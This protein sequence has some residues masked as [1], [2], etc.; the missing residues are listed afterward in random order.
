MED[1]PQLQQAVSGGALVDD[2]LSDPTD[3]LFVEQVSGTRACCVQPETVP[4]IQ[5]TFQPEGQ[6]KISEEEVKEVSESARQDKYDELIALIESQQFNDVVEVEL[7]SEPTDE[8]QHSE[9]QLDQVEGRHNMEESCSPQQNRQSLQLVLDTGQ[10]STDVQTTTTPVLEVSP[11]L[12]LEVK[13]KRHIIEEIVL[14]D[15]EKYYESASSNSSLKKLKKNSTVKGSLPESDVTVQAAVE[16]VSPADVEVV[17][18]VES[19]TKLES[20]PPRPPCSTVNSSPSDSPQT[21]TYIVHHDVPVRTDRAGKSP[22]RKS[23]SGSETGKPESSATAV[24]ERQGDTVN[25]HEAVNVT[26]L[27]CKTETA[28]VV[29]TVPL[30]TAS[31]NTGDVKG[32]LQTVMYEVKYQV[33][34]NKKK[35]NVKPSTGS[36]VVTESTVNPSTSAHGISESKEQHPESLY[37]AIINY[38]ARNVEK[39][40]DQPSTVTYIT[41]YDY[42]SLNVKRPITAPQDSKQV[43][44]LEKPCCQV[45]RQVEMVAETCNVGVQPQPTR[46]SVHYEQQTDIDTLLPSI[47]TS[48]H[49]VEPTVEHVV[50]PVV[51]VTVPLAA[52]TSPAQPQAVDSN[53]ET[54]TYVIDS[55]V[56]FSEPDIDNPVTVTSE[57]QCKAS[58]VTDFKPSNDVITR[59]Y[60][61]HYD[62]PTSAK[63]KPSGKVTEKQPTEPEVLKTKSQQ[64][65]GD[66]KDVVVKQACLSTQ[67][68][69]ITYIVHYDLPTKHR[70]LAKVKKPSVDVSDTGRQQLVVTESVDV[71]EP[72][73]ELIST[74][75]TKVHKVEVSVE[76]V[77]VKQVGACSDGATGSL[78]LTGTEET[79]EKSVEAEQH[80]QTITYIIN[81]EQPWNVKPHVLKS[82]TRS[83]RAVKESNIITD[84]SE[85]CPSAK[86]L[87]EQPK[88]LAKTDVNDVPLTATCVIR[89][90]AKEGFKETVDTEEEQKLQVQRTDEVVS[91]VEAITESCHQQ[92]GPAVQPETVTYIVNYEPI[93]KLSDT[94]THHSQLKEQHVLG[95]KTKQVSW[96]IGKKRQVGTEKHGEIS[97]VS[98]E[99][100]TYVI[101][102]QI[103]KKNKSPKNIFAVKFKDQSSDRKVKDTKKPDEKEQKVVLDETSEMQTV[104]A[105]S[106]VADVPDTVTYEQ[107]TTPEIVVV[108]APAE[109]LDPRTGEITY[110]VE[111]RL[112]TD[113]RG[114]I[115]TDDVKQNDSDDLEVKPRPSVELTVKAQPSESENRDYEV[116][117][118]CVPSI[119]LEP[120]GADMTHTIQTFELAVEEPEI[121]PAKATVAASGVAPPVDLREETVT[122]IVHYA[123]LDQLFVRKNKTRVS[124]TTK[125]VKKQNKKKAVTEPEK[126]ETEEAGVAVVKSAEETV[127]FIVTYPLPER[128]KGKKSSSSK[129]TAAAGPGT[130]SGSGETEVKVEAEI[131]EV[132]VETSKEREMMVPGQFKVEGK[133]EVVSTAPSI[134][135]YRADIVPSNL[136]SPADSETVIYVVHH[137]E[138][139]VRQQQQQPRIDQDQQSPTGKTKFALFGSRHSTNKDK[140]LVTGELQGTTDITEAGLGTAVTEPVLR[141]TVTGTVGTHPVPGTTVTSSGQLETDVDQLMVTPSPET[142]TYIVQYDVEPSISASKAA[143]AIEGSAKVRPKEERVMMTPLDD[144]PS[145]TTQ[146]TAPANDVAVTS[147]VRHFVVIAIDFGTT[148]SGYAFSFSASLSSMVGEDQM[149]E[150]QPDNVHVMRRWEGGDPGVVNH[151]APTTLLL[152][153]TGEFHSFGFTARDFYHDLSARQAKKWLYFDKFKMVLHNNDELNSKTE[154]AASNG[155]RV[156]ATMVF[157]HALRFFRKHAIQEISDQCGTKILTDDIRWV[158]TVPSIWQEP[159]KQ[160]MRLAAYQAGIGSI[161]K[162]EQL[163][164][165]LEPEAASIYVRKLHLHQLV[166]EGQEALCRPKSPRSPLI[167]TPEPRLADVSFQTESLGQTLTNVYWSVQRQESPVYNISTVADQVD[168]PGTRYMVVDCGGGTVDITVHELSSDNCSL[169]ELYKATGGPFGSMAVDAEFE[170]LLVNIF[171]ADF[172][173][174]FKTKRPAGW[175]D[176]MMAFESRKRAANPLS[177]KPLNVSLPFSFIDYHKKYRNGPVETAVRQYNNSDVIWSSQGMLRLLPGAM[178]RLFQPTLDNIK[179]AIGNVL[180]QPSVRGVKF[181]FLVGGFAE[182]PMLQTDIRNEFQ[183]LLKIIIP[184]EVSLAVL[185]GAVCFGVNPNVVTTRRSL[186]TYGVSVVRPFVRGR[187][188]D[189]KLIKLNDGSEWCGDVFDVLVLANQPV[190]L[191][192]TIVRRYRPISRASTPI[193]VFDIYCTDRVDMLYTTDNAV[194]Q[195]ARLRLEFETNTTEVQLRLNFSSTEIC[196]SALDLLANRT[197]RTNIDFLSM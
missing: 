197:V 50:E 56:S 176:L 161:D 157:V 148:F 196:V 89:E 182:S 126:V 125:K 130:G 118:V 78:V 42:P 40:H 102:Y 43:V 134:S 132:T 106:P 146:W 123:P 108:A 122:Y 90:D 81:Y 151:K 195:C 91:G 67:P 172:I 115:I 107:T 34:T 109:R 23:T 180:N 164:I 29:G 95:T 124:D 97:P 191:G 117:P 104:I 26:S 8:I 1:Q 111:Y 159:A 184:H 70:K 11:G 14:V 83:E 4:H 45:E 171:G 149:T 178:K 62:W 101:A 28:S 136:Q 72:D 160:F 68:E 129:A 2:Q 77:E 65:P 194:K 144:Q 193:A 25:I 166:P 153:P 170:R 3:R 88:I 66:G 98:Q 86:V 44:V 128:K 99:T 15:S 121:V 69:V 61:V 165:A 150:V 38:A 84:I 27:G 37:L 31:S 20:L 187:D 120:T 156:L 7:I 54:V 119:E 167:V 183:H 17:V 48:Q 32:Q 87:V 174:V 162:P 41:H 190:H 21:V 114:R 155:Q 35:K 76:P 163:V 52:T 94:K 57:Q 145:V 113:D 158:I 49:V 59:T 131:G 24:T 64:P 36:A 133:A 169:I 9:Q 93:V 92:P 12:R 51:S 63:H 105:A 16:Q 75:S 139:R 60:I 39:L 55:Q 143:G 142:V 135:V 13:Q 33:N 6:V 47:D 79:R 96:K 137:E 58:D 100:I 185:R 30:T 112:S 80:E 141:Q 82:R 18:A 85:S 127:T 186:A 5:F 19:G 179:S 103:S 22:K 138:H 73:T 110:V 168:I 173:E 152:T 189:S 192:Q 46:S 74:S 154:I 140:Q 181:L 177:T 188:P 147:P 116:E 71:T 53:M 10:V 175:V